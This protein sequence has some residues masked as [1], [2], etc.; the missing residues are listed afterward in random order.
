MILSFVMTLF[1]YTLALSIICVELDPDAHMKC[2]R[3]LSKTG[4]DRS[5]IRVV[6]TVGR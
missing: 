4:C 2:I 1:G 6:L 5:G 3:F